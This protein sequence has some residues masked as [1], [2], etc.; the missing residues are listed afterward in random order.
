MNLKKFKII[1]LT[2]IILSLSSVQFLIPQSLNNDPFSKEEE[3]PDDLKISYPLPQYIKWVVSH[4]VIIDD[5]G[6]TFGSAT[7]ESIV[8]FYP[9]ASG[10]GTII[11]SGLIIRNSDAYFIIEYCGFTNSSLEFPNKWYGL[12]LK[13]V[14]NRILLEWVSE[15][16]L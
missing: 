6:A 13:N 4:E 7:W 14:D 8:N 2:S 12:A 11:F 3:I 9:W 10:Q 15:S 16:L 5:T 1:F